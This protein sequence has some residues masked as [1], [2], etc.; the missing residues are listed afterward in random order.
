MCCQDKEE[1]NEEK[2]FEDAITSDIVSAENE[3]DDVTNKSEY[4]VCLVTVTRILVIT[5]KNVNHAT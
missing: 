3:Q 4:C 5:L 2:V 1:F